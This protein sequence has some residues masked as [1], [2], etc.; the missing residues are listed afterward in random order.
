M[1]VYLFL[2]RVWWCMELSMGSGILTPCTSVAYQQQAFSHHFHHTQTLMPWTSSFFSYILTIVCKLYKIN[3]LILC[4]LVHSLWISI[5][6]WAR[7][8]QSE[9][10]LSESLVDGTELSLHGHTVTQTYTHSIYTY[11]PLDHAGVWSSEGG[12]IKGGKAR[13]AED[14]YK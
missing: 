14:M 5:R 6:E 7:S 2:Y 10:E 13:E 8:K 1:C 4:L 9:P 3:V 12:G 11:K